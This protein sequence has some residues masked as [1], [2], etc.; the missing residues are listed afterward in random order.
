[1]TDE[2]NVPAVESTVDM[3]EMATPEAETE[4]PAT[5]TPAAE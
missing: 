5:E 4:M 1:M 3:P 2:T